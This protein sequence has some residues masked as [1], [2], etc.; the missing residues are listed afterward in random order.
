MEHGITPWV[1]RPGVKLTMLAQIEAMRKRLTSSHD[2]DMTIENVQGDR[3]LTVASIT[4]EDF[5]QIIYPVV[6][7]FKL[8][9]QTAYASFQRGKYL[10]KRIFHLLILN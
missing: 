4:R 5:A 6:E 3:D 2:T 10:V 9:L 8:F 7:E 1:K